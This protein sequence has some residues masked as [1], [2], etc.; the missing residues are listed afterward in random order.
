MWIIGFFVAPSFDSENFFFAA[1]KL[2]NEKRKKN[3][4]RKY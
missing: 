1:A 4:K 2:E 3:L